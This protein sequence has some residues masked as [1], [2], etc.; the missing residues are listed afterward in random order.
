MDPPQCLQSPRLKHTQLFINPQSTWHR[1]A[2]VLV[3]VASSSWLC[4]GGHYPR[5]L[6]IT[7]IFLKFTV[8]AHHLC[9]CSICSIGMPTRQ[10]TTSRACKTSG[11]WILPDLME[12]D[13]QCGKNDLIPSP[14]QKLEHSSRRKCKR[15]QTMKPWSEKSAET[16]LL[17]CHGTVLKQRCTGFLGALV[18][19]RGKGR[20]FRAQ[21]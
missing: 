15:A 2:G 8:T 7:C 12:H 6:T 5:F 11:S 17:H 4:T 18:S 21:W 10:Y 14:H 1:E 13:V 9:T 3:V 16:T 20:T 19:R